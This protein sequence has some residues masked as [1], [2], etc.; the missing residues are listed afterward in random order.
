MLEIE[1]PLLAADLLIGS[2]EH[3]EI[4]IIFLADV[5]VQHALVGAGLGRDTIDAGPG[6]AMGRKLLLR[7]F[8]DAKPHAF[9]VALPSE[10]SLCL[11]QSGRS[12]D[13][14]LTVTRARRHCEERSD[15]AI[16]PLTRDSGLLRFAR[17]DGW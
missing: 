14:V 13:A 2:F 11:R 3:R 7:G 10:I 15:E 17:N 8:E 12:L 1:S 6:E 4:E 9:G 5:V 16:R